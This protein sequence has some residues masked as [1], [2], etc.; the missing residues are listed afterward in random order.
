MRRFTLMLASLLVLGAVPAYAQT[1]LFVGAQVT[2]ASLNYKDAAQ[3]L[4][5]GSGYG[6]HAGLTLGS[7]LGVLVNYDKNT[8]GSSGGNT[9]LGQWDLLGRLRFI[10]AGPLK[11]YLTAG[12]TGRT[13]AS[14]IYNGTTGDFDF[15][16]TNPTAGLTAQFMVTPKLAIDGGLLWTFG[17]FNDTG[18]YSAS[19]VEA[20]GSRVSV[21]AS[22]Y[23]FG[24]N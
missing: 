18:G 9:D 10:G 3:N 23:L 14:K 1:G 16:G 17:K 19:R 20:T 4:D 6:V 2:G 7:S 8:L 11:T 12:I 5:F 22:F 15:S 13:A 21:G 24:G